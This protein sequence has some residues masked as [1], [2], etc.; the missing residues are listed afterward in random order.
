V[1]PWRLCLKGNDNFFLFSRT[2]G[3]KS[4]YADT[5]YEKTTIPV[6]Y[7]YVSMQQLKCHT[8]CQGRTLKATADFRAAWLSPTITLTSSSSI[9]MV[10]A[11]RSLCN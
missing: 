11:L 9:T 2:I 10:H 5:I 7:L 4:N 3:S 8:P 1:R 6:Q